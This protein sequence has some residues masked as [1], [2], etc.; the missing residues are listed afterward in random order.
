MIPSDLVWGALGLLV[1]VMILSYLIGDN[2]FFRLAVHLFIGVTA[3]FL[4]VLTLKQILWPYLYQPILFGTWVERL[5]V[6]IPLL[7]CLLLI[8]S[9]FPRFV[10]LGRTPLAFLAGLTAAL[11]IGGS[12]FGTII[13]QLKTITAGFERATWLE[14]AT[15][16]PLIKIIE[17]VI[18]LIGTVSAL[19]YFHF[20]RQRVD[21]TQ[22][23]DAP[24]RVILWWASISEVFIGL[25]LGTVFAGVFS[26]ALLAL[27]DRL[28]FIGEFIAQ[29]KGGS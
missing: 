28:L 3:G 25:A 17:A 18:M 27:I 11:V 2:L 16:H 20:G 10:G 8:I 14:S 15:A 13:P 6:L 22:D 7:L 1:T 23:K 4:A 24:S 5:W 19:S 26:S 9:Q 29:L 21:S 12:V